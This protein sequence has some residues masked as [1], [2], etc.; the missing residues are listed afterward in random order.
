MLGSEFLLYHRDSKKK[1]TFEDSAYLAETLNLRP[2]AFIGKALTNR[3]RICVDICGIEGPPGLSER[4]MG[5]QLL[6]DK[7]EEVLPNQRFGHRDKR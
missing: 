7:M 1:D 3:R 6:G 2:K 4:C 5:C